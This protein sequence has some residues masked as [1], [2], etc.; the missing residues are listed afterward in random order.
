MYTNFSNNFISVP[1][2]DYPLLHAVKGGGYSFTSR[3]YVCMCVCLCVCPLR[4]FANSYDIT[5]KLGP[6]YD[7][8]DPKKLI[9]FE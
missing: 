7:R 9:E 1:F 4:N 6:I 5:F 8:M 2:D 3:L